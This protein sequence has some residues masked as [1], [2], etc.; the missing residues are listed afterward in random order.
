MI[1][2]LACGGQNDKIGSHDKETHNC[3]FLKFVF[4]YCT[5]KKKFVFFTIQLKKIPFIADKNIKPYMNMEFVTIRTK[6]L[7]LS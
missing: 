4:F 5:K 7:G 3:C 6:K 2:V 1:W